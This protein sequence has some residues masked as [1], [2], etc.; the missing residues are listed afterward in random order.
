MKREWGGARR[1]EVRVAPSRRGEAGRGASGAVAPAR[2]EGGASGA[3]ARVR[4][5]L[6]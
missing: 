5:S 1:G 3:V 6:L 4:Y 2:G